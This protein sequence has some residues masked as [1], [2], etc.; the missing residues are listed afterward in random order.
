[1]RWDSLFTDLDAQAEALR[2]AE[3]LADA[4]E[5]SRAE[6]AQVGL[7]D[8]LRA[9][10]GRS[11]RVQLLGG[12]VVHGTLRGCGL[13]WLLL[14]EQGGRQTLV[15]IGAVRTVAGLGR[16]AVTAAHTGQVE[17]RSSLRLALRAI[18]RDRSP[19]R[20]T[21]VD[22]TQLRGTIARAGADFVELT[23]PVEPAAETVCVPYP[24]LAA[25][26]RSIGD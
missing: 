10:Y 12:A 4:E 19:V 22:A 3:L 15:P 20:I 1:M 18:A 24:V 2:Q 25:V 11:L 14:E 5:M 13:D 23:V 6:F 26:Q 7:V 9:A 21:L 8:R 17:A 16:H